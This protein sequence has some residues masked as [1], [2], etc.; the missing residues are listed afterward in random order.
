MTPAARAFLDRSSGN[1]ASLRMDKTIEV[2][3]FSA[4]VALMDVRGKV[5]KALGWKYV[6]G[7]CGTTAESQTSS[8]VYAL[9]ERPPPDHPS[10]CLSI[11]V[12]ELRPGDIKV[13]A[14]LGDSLTVSTELRQA[15]APAKPC[16]EST[17]PPHWLCV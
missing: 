1:P 11:L 8:Q 6:V 2:V 13:V 10:F 15:R 4:L 7:T 14:A 12:H 9:K 16:A 3:A 17:L 5:A